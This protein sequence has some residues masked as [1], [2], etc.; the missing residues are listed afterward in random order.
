MTSCSEEQLKTYDGE[1]YLHFTA[2]ADRQE[3]H[4]TFNFATQA[5]L[6]T[7]AD[8][9]VS[10]TLWGFP[11]E[12]SATYRVSI[13]S[14]GTTGQESTDYT[15]VGTG[16]FG[17]HL[18]T[19]TFYIH[20][21]RNAELLNTNFQLRLQLEQADEYQVGPQEYRCVTVNVVDELTEPQWWSQSIAGKLGAYSPVKHRLL[22][23]F[24]DGEVFTSIDHYTGIQFN[25]L[26]SQFKSWW[27]SQWE[28]GK[29]HYYTDDQTTPLYETIQD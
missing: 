23:I 13:V 25:Q 22:I 18:A 8:V 12:Q 4:V 15:P 29:Y 9:P 17:A 24:M 6:S 21:R 28:L 26:I 2:A 20:V 16:S 5:P 19:D 10:L 27:R 7:E 1:R 14:E 11:F 3:Q